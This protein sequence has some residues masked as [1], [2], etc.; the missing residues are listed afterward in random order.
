MASDILHIKDGYYFDVPKSLYQVNY[1]S[2]GDFRDSVGAWFVRN[3]DDYQ[4]WEAGHIVDGLITRVGVAPSDTEDLISQ[5]HKWQHADEKRHG[6]P[7]DR[8]IN[9]RIANIEAKAN[10]WAKNGAPGARDKVQAYIADHPKEPHAWMMQLVTDPAKSSEWGRLQRDMNAPKVVDDY[11]ASDRGRWSGEKVHAYNQHLAG[12]IFIPQP[13]GT[14]R[15]AY[16]RES[17]FAISKFMIIEVVVAI[18]LL[19]AFAWLGSKVAKGGA[20]RGKAWNLLESFLTFIRNDV[21]MPG[22]GEHDTDR[23]LPFFWTIFMF[24]LGCNLMG[25]LPWVGAPSAALGMTA[26]LALI[27]FALGVFLGIRTFGLVGY[28]KNLMPSLGLP[29]YLAVIIVPMVWVIEFA[30]LFIKHGILAIRLLANMV[31]GHMV[32]LGI[33]GLAVGV[34]AARMGMFQWS[35]VAVVSILAT[36]ALSFME[37]FVAF[38]QAYVFT[39]LAAMFIG[40]SIHHH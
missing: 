8:Y 37:L 22:M 23:F 4:E 29:I 26:A 21:V 9:D 16:E 35:L 2:A 38:L 36:T 11:V 33:L 39:L 34:E 24:I 6:R 20:P 30:S 31:A 14:I 5:W 13:F 12:K 28:L 27:V 19:V 25:M 1:R 17:G 40:G 32:L 3:D 18:L 10:T 7:L 15:N